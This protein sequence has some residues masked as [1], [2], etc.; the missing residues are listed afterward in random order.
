M[1]EQLCPDPTIGGQ[2]DSMQIQILNEN[3]TQ[4]A[5]NIGRNGFDEVK[6][7]T[8]Q[9]LMESQD[10]DLTETDR[11]E[12]APTSTEKRTLTFIKKAITLSLPMYQF[13]LKDLLK[14]AKYEKIIKSYYFLIF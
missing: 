12:E 4:I 10:E 9:Q 7:K 1:P 11:K 6:L 5:N 13:N 3:I 14:V 2:E 8:I